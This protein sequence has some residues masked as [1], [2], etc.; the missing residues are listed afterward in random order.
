MQT[1]VISVGN[2]VNIDDFSV[3]IKKMYPSLQI[4]VQEANATHA[5]K[6]TGTDDLKRIRASE[7]KMFKNMSM[8]YFEWI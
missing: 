2:D 5:T 1:L 3:Q 6:F 7:F 4:V 8:Y